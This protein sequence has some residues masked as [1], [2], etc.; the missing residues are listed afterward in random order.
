[1]PSVYNSNLASTLLKLKPVSS[2]YLLRIQ[3]LKLQDSYNGKVVVL[4]QGQN[5]KS[6]DFDI[7]GGNGSKKVGCCVEE[8][9]KDA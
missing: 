7:R 2:K 8:K 3:R 4:S 5:S 1:M 6:G 9:T